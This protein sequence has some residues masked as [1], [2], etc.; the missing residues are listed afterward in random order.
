VAED[1]EHLL[2][3]AVAPDDRRDLV[4]PRQ[5]VEVDRKVLERRRELEALAQ[6][7]LAQLA[8]AEVRRHP[9]H[10]RI[11]LDAVAADDHHRCLLALVQDAGHQVRRLDGLT[12]RSAGVMER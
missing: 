11:R 2:D 8:V 5:Q 7:L 4:L 3:L 9:R 6:L 10:Q 1:L 12:A